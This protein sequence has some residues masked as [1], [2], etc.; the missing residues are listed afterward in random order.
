MQYSRVYIESIGYELPPNVV[1]TASLEDRIASVYREF[2]L[3]LRQVEGL[4][5]IRERRMWNPGQTMSEGAAKAGRKALDAAG[6][7]GSDM[8]MLIY[9]GVCRDQ[10]EPATSCAVADA[11]RVNGSSQVYDVSNAC[12]G[13]MNGIIHVANAI[14][15]GQARAGLVVSCES[16][17]QIIDTT[18][19]R[20]I[21]NR[22]METFRLSI[23]TL[24]GGSGAVGVV[25][26]G[27][28]MT[29]GGHRL[30]GGVARSAPEHHDLCRWGPDSG[31]AA[32][33]HQIM[34]TDAPAVLQHGVTLGVRTWEDL[35]R[36]LNW[37]PDPQLKVIC[38]QV[39][40]QHRMT[41]LNTL[42]LNQEQDFST[43]EYLGNIGTVSLPI[44]AAIAEERGFLEKGDRVC[45]LGIGSGLNCLMLGLEW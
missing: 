23:A 13:V 38:H 3:G 15:L 35:L 44:S 11:L 16:C 26:T 40:K 43:F 37:R 30:A 33:A 41:I 12:L 31:V 25:V 34:Q 20:L 22:D 32:G 4:T 45:F 29:R 7:S 39:G 9:A 6:L 27:D 14:E 2:G 19:D 28:T 36:E 17:R 1:T 24:T 18:I 5:G 8:D 21:K 42:G 10:L